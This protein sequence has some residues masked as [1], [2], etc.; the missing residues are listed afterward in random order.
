MKGRRLDNWRALHSPL[1]RDSSSE[2]SQVCSCLMH[3]S[4]GASFPS[5]L[6]SIVIGGG[7]QGSSWS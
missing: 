3:G 6:L 4:P 5:T 1:S 7:P 2:E